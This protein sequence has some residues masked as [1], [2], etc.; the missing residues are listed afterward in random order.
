MFKNKNVSVKFE[1]QLI[2]LKMTDQLLKNVNLM[3]IVCITKRLYF[4]I[5]GTVHACTVGIFGLQI[6]LP[7]GK[8]PLSFLLKVH[9]F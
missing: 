2:K 7:E 8:N 6:S 5:G 9:V 1:V 4:P 3:P